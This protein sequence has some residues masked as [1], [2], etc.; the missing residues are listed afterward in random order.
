MSRM[1]WVLRRCLLSFLIVFAHVAAYAGDETWSYAATFRVAVD[2][3]GHAKVLEAGPRT[4]G[5]VVAWTTPQIE[6]WTFEPAKRDGVAAAAEAWLLLRYDVRRDGAGYAYEI[7]EV[8]IG[9]GIATVS[10]PEYP[11]NS[12]RKDCVGTMKLKVAIDADGNPTSVTEIGEVKWRVVAKAVIKAVKQWHFAPQR[13]GGAGVAEN[14][15]VSVDFDL[16]PSGDAPV[17][18]TRAPLAPGHPRLEQVAIS[19]KPV[20]TLI[21]GPRR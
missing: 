2:A 21:S 10:L 3:T 7:S 11:G 16:T 17:P 5:N 12:V 14:V 15:T 9:P 18:G 20:V 4:P 1:P 8:G 13:I 6:R 19:E